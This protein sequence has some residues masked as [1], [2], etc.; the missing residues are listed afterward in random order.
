MRLTYQRSP[1]FGSRG[2]SVI[3][4]IVLHATASDS[5][6]GTLAWFMNTASKVS[7]HY[8]IGKDGRIIKMVAVERSAWHAGRSS[9]RLDDGTLVTGLNSRSVGIELVNLNDGK[10]IYPLPQIEALVELLQVIR[11]AEP[12][13]KYLVGHSEINRGKSDPRG[14]DLGHL[15]AS[16]GWKGSNANHT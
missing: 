13:I 5:L 14:L 12:S 8:V 15:R 4:T 7:A 1:N 2:G 6:A 16:L 10:D 9:L 11:K 3:D